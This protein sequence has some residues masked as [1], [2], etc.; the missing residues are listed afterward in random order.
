MDI[1]GYGPVKDAAVHE[2][3]A[4]VATDLAALTDR[5]LSSRAA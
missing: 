3:K 1:R 5:T 2:V 4:R